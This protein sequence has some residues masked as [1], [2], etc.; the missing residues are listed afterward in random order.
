[1]GQNPEASV[2]DLAVPRL[3][4]LGLFPVIRWLTVLA[5]V[6]VSIA[7]LAWAAFWLAPW[8]P[9]SGWAAPRLA[10]WLPNSGWGPPARPGR[11]S[12]LAIMGGAVL[13]GM[14]LVV[15]VRRLE[16]RARARR[17]RAWL[18]EREEVQREQSLATAR[19]AAERVDTPEAVLVL[20]LVQSTELIR[21]QGDAFFRDLLRR[22]ETAFIPV[23][24]SHGSRAVDG[25]GDGFLFCFDRAE[26][27]LDAV[28]AMYA[29]LPTINA[30]LPSGVEIA[31]RASLHLGPTFADTRGNRAGLAVLKT[32]RL[33]SVMEALHG[34][35]AGRNSL[36]I[37]EEAL[38]S[39][40]PAAGPAKLLGNVPLRGFPGTHA[41]YQLEI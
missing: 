25:H 40:G 33:G 37:S 7:G 39:L 1:V 23:A 4:G 41:V 11:I 2:G 38:A 14:V 3:P 32:V 18:R 34:R 21:E 22:I 10:P 6:L 29:R 27:A 28:R 16:T 24:R 17:Y 8:V 36:V 13:V 15:G 19:V 20:D 26:P 35:G 30:A 31:F 9:G 5:T 12:E